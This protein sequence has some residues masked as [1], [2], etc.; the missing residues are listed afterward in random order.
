MEC[1][2]QQNKII[3]KVVQELYGAEFWDQ[4]FWFRSAEFSGSMLELD[5]RLNEHRQQNWVERIA[6]GWVR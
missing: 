6:R 5:A 2:R 1:S 4:V 3:S